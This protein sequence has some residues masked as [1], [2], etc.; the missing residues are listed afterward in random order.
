MKIAGAVL[1]LSL[2]ACHR[3]ELGSGPHTADRDYARPAA[4]VWSAAIEGVKDEGLDVRGATYDVHG[5]TLEAQ[6]VRITVFPLRES[7]CRVSVRVG[8][9][10]A[11]LA[12]RLHGRI[13]AALEAKPGERP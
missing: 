2:A 1:W 4:R 13:A 6:A 11:A 9:D 10:D 8:P 7:R 5:G 12:R 3:H